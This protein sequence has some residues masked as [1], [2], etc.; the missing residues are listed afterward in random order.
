M[1]RRSTELFASPYPAVR[2]ARHCRKSVHVDWTVWR[3]DGVKHHLWNF[4][5]LETKAAFFTA[6]RCADHPPSER[7]LGMRRKDHASEVDGGTAFNDLSGSNLL[8]LIQ[9][10]CS[11]RELDR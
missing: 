9:S 4:R 7:V 1:L 5:S 6:A 2:E 10:L 11:R 3:V 8:C